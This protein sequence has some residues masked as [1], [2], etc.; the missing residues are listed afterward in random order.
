MH[1]C[2]AFS[3]LVEVYSPF[4]V[5]SPFQFH[6]SKLSGESG[7]VQSTKQ[8]SCVVVLMAMS[9]NGNRLMT[10]SNVK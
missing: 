5:G 6:S 10:I 7:H 3:C 4:Q 9:T 8:K 1:V 2:I